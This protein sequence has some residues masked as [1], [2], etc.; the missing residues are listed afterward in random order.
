M[1]KEWKSAFFNGCLRDA[2]GCE[3]NYWRSRTLVESVKPALT[4]V[5]NDD[6]SST[7]VASF[8]VNVEVDPIPQRRGRRRACRRSEL[9]DKH[10][11]V[12]DEVNFVWLATFSCDLSLLRAVELMDLMSS[13]R[14][15]TN[16]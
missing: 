15:N 11:R 13:T 7:D 4:V 3:L 2:D 14:S 5:A 10:K 16:G 8:S 9:R 6:V 12:W 1:Q